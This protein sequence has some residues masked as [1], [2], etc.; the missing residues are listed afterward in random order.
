[1]IGHILTEKEK[2]SFR[3]GFE[4]ELIWTSLVKLACKLPQRN[5][6]S[7]AALLGHFES[8]FFMFLFFSALVSVS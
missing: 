5:F 4:T 7:A 2:Q 1:M 8:S 6:F 3:S